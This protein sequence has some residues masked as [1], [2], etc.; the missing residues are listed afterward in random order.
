MTVWAHRNRDRRDGDD[1]DGAKCTCASASLLASTCTGV[2]AINRVRR[3]WHAEISRMQDVA[4][5]AFE[6]VWRLLCHRP[7]PSA[8]PSDSANWYASRRSD[9]SARE[10]W[11][12]TVPTDDP[13]SAAICA[14]D[15]SS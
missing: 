8:G 7:T 5:P 2:D 10:A 14:S 1:R 15:M 9:A 11:L 4:Q 13:I 3:N 12:F 6:V